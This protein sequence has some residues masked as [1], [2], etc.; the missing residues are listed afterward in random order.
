MADTEFDIASR[1][2]GLVGMPAVSDFSSDTRESA[3][4]GRMYEARVKQLL[5]KYRWEFARKQQV[6]TAAASTPVGRWD[7]AYELPADCLIVRAFTLN[8]FPVEYQLAGDRYLYANLTTADEPVLD[9]TYRVDEPYFPPHFTQALE[10]DLAMIAGAGIA[11]KAELADFARDMFEIAFEEAKSNDAQQVTA[12]KMQV[13]R[14][15]TF[16]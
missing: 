7:L 5:G 12:K 13:T 9:Y 10:W 3:F 8:D 15:T 16:R 14:L 6:L 2:L 11:R 1:A 4:M